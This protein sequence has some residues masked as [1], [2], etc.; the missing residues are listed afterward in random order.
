[1]FNKTYIFTFAM[2][3]AGITQ[4]RPHFGFGF[5][6]SPWGSSFGFGVSSSHC[7][8]GYSIPIRVHSCAPKHVIIE[9]VHHYHDS[10]K[11]SLKRLQKA[12]ELRRIKKE[13]KRKMRELEYFQELERQ[14]KI[15]KEIS[16]Q[17]KEVELSNLKRKEAELNKK[18]EELDQYLLSLKIEQSK[19]EARKLALSSRD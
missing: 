16:K 9:E 5:G 3:F 13:T 15:A 6:V 1:M 11:E 12:E 7:D 4:A 19:L 14:K 8:A 18:L 10:D 17:Q 2:L